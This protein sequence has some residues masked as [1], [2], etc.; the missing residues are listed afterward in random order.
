MRSAPVFSTPRA[1]D[2]CDPNPTLTFED[3]F[4]AGGKVR[5]TWTATDACGNARTATQMITVDCTPTLALVASIRVSPENH[6][7]VVEW[8]TA[9]EVGTLAFDLYRQTDG[10]AWVQVNRDLVLALN[11]MTGG[12]YKV[13]DPGAAIPGTYVYKLVEW[14]DDGRESEVGTYTLSVFEPVRLTSATRQGALLK[15]EWQGGMPPYRLEKRLS[16]DGSG[17]APSTVTGDTWSEVPLSDPSATGALV[18]MGEPAAFFRIRHGSQ[19][20]D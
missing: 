13:Q 8:T 6:L 20:S 10:G 3:T 9:S 4:L 2:T 11:S 18:P 5:R 1:T 14:R 7:A 17:T 15:L 16:L 19:S 12:T